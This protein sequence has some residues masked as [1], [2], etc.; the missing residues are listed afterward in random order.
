MKTFSEKVSKKSEKVAKVLKKNKVKEETT[1]KTRSANAKSLSR[2]RVPAIKN[3]EKEHTQ[4][5]S[6]KAQEF[7]IEPSSMPMTQI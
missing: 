6:I 2:K 7:E 3:E 5:N 1:S 4:L